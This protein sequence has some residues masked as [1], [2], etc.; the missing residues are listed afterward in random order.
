M[1]DF[2]LLMWQLQGNR[3][4]TVYD[5]AANLPV[6]EAFNTDCW[7]ML[8]ADC[9]AASDL[10]LAMAVKS[11]SWVPVVDFGIPQ[12]ERAGNSLLVLCNS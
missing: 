1:Y 4:I 11:L 2:A 9:V 10:E 5:A 7:L 12:C 6:N 3:R 8:L